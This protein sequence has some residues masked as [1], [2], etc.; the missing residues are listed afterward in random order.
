MSEADKQQPMAAKVKD[1]H[2]QHCVQAKS[3]AIHSNMCVQHAPSSETYLEAAQEGSIVSEG[4]EIEPNRLLS[5]V[6]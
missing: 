5:R 6:I 3:V 1:D 4:G 2:S